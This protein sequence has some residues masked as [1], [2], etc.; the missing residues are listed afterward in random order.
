M[1]ASPASR[2]AST[3]IPAVTTAPVTGSQLRRHRQRRTVSLAGG[4]CVCPGG[5]HQCRQVRTVPRFRHSAEHICLECILDELAQT[6]KHRSAGSAF[7]KRAG[8]GR[9][10]LP[11]LPG[12]RNVRFYPGARSAAATISS[13]CWRK[14]HSSIDPL[15][16]AQ[17]AWGSGWPGCGIAS[18]NPAC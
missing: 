9:P 16:V 1:A 10:I 7:A 11:G 18:A 12:G 2:C 3:P 15:N 14:P 6:L 13:A 5:L 17:A 4:R 8:G